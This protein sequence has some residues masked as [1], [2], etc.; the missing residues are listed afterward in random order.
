MN[1]ATL[2]TSLKKPVSVDAWSKI[3]SADGATISEEIKTGGRK[4]D[5]SQSD[6]DNPFG[7]A[8]KNSATAK[9]A[10]KLKQACPSALAGPSHLPRPGA[11]R[12]LT[13]G[14]SQDKVL[15]FV[16]PEKVG[17]WP[18]WRP[19]PEIERRE[20]ELGELSEGAEKTRLMAEL[21]EL[22]NH[23]TVNVRPPLPSITPLSGVCS[24]RARF[25]G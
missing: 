13:P 21:D 11:G 20:A 19:E 15:G 2:A 17:F 9:K 18:S 8:P 22:V 5:L 7:M 3:L 16:D 12:P 4:L 14:P 24:L 10:W 25:H 1:L 6:S 23:G